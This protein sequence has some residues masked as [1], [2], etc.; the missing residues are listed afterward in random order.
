MDAYPSVVFTTNC[1]VTPADCMEIKETHPGERSRPQA[2]CSETR[3]LWGLGL[4]GGWG[5]QEITT[6]R[7][8]RGDVYQF[9]QIKQLFRDV[10]EVV[11]EQDVMADGHLGRAPR[12]AAT[13]AAPIGRQSIWLGY[14]V[15]GGASADPAGSA[16]MLEAGRVSRDIAQRPPAGMTG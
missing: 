8:S 3:E 9:A 14:L 2:P 12:G 16:V 7:G 4:C 11:A 1:P 6:G 13:P 10:V 5:R 15:I